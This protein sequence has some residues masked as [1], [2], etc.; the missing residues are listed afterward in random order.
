MRL[1]G[2]V[3]VSALAGCWLVGCGSQSTGKPA[4]DEV[5]PSED[6]GGAADGGVDGCIDDATF[7]A[8]TASP[9]LQ[10][11]CLGCHVA[12]GAAG[13]TRYVLVPGAD[14]AALQANQTMVASLVADVGSE[15]VL[16]KPT[17]G[18]THGG[19]LRFDVLDGRYAVLHE[20]VARTASPGGCGHPGEAPLTCDVAAI[21]PGSAPLRRLT[22]HQ[23]DVLVL[24]VYGVVL[25]DGLFPSTQPGDGFRTFALNNGVSASGAESMMLAAE[26]VADAVPLSD[27][28]DCGDG[29]E[30]CGRAWVLDRAAAAFR[31]PLSESEAAL[32]TRFLDAGVGAEEGVRMGI[33]VTL[34]LPQVVY[35]DTATAGPV[36]QA[37]ELEAADVVAV[38]PFAVASRLSFFLTDGPPDAELWAAAAAGELATRAQ[39]SAHAWRLV[40]HPRSTGVVA[41]FHQD[42]LHLDQ[43][44]DML[45]DTARYPGWTD[46]LVAD[47]H[48]ETDLFTTE[49]VWMGD[50]TFDAL[51]FSNAT[52]VTPELATIYGVDV[53]GSGW[54]RVALDGDVRPGVLGRVGF[55]SAH[56]Y[57]AASAPVR[58]GAWVL[59]ELLCEQLQPPPEVDLTLPDESA[60][61][62]TIRDKLAV[63]TSDTSC[64]TCHDRIDPIGFSF[65]HFDG[66]GAWRATWESGIA[67][68]ATGSLELPSGDFDGYAEMIGLVAS[69]D[70]ARECY[71]RR[72]FE[73]GVGRRSEPGDA[74]S[75]RTLGQRFDESGGDIR[76]LLVDVALTDAFLYRTVDGA[77]PLSDDTDGGDD[78]AE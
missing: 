48:T 42:W 4:G 16:A 65:E 45:K 29:P 13:S 70:R 78:A 75:V 67:V 46:A 3:W 73:Y 69:S 62:L 17:G 34:Q 10:S 28:L 12:D 49:V 61:I 38:D 31:R 5:T 76:A 35:L 36:V 27:V 68:D 54:Q 53:D 14:A 41:G 44:D 39:V 2:R 8:E 26:H 63:H 33:F 47:M 77:D 9:V 20:L 40:S 50:A 1:D 18:Q 60:E 19:G 72:W 6:S 66:I 56:S 22:D 55:L 59:E 23:F 58:R 64:R 25:P 52:W 21:R 32:V 57:A 74:C 30:A 71:A 37:A 24:D 43:L 15:T 51:M 7:F 11:E